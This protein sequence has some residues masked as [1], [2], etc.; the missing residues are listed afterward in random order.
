M[1][2]ARP[3]NPESQSIFASVSPGFKQPL[4]PPTHTP[5]GYRSS[6]TD[7]PSFTRGPCAEN[8]LLFQAKS[9]KL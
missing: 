3:A 6:P 1:N 2:T 4:P 5:L 9:V 7:A 8:A